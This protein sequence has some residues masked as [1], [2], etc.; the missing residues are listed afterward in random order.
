MAAYSLADRLHKT[1]GEIMAMP[2]EE[3]LGWIAYCKIKAEKES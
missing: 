1:L 2:V 3:F